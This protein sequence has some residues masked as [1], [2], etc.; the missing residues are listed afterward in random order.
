MLIMGIAQIPDCTCTTVYPT[1]GT[2]YIQPY[3][4]PS[5]ATNCKCHP[6]PDPEPE[7]DPTRIASPAVGL[8]VIEHTRP[9]LAFLANVGVV[10][11]KVAI[12]IPAVVCG[13]TAGLC[14]GVVASVRAVWR[15]WPDGDQP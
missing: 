8:W 12:S 7:T 11:G 15:S 9:L 3:P 14:V 2:S 5:L 1:V 13:A 4:K 6:I 10:A